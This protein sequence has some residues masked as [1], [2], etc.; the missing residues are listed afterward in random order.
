[1]RRI[2]LVVLVA[3][4]LITAC[5]PSLIP[6]P[7]ATAT[8]I[9]AET[10]TPSFPL[11][12]RIQPT[13]TPDPVA[14]ATARSRQEIAGLANTQGLSNTQVV[15]LWNQKTGLE[16][17]VF[18]YLQS[19]IDKTKAW[20]IPHDQVLAASE[21][22][23]LSLR[24]APAIPGLTR[25]LT[26]DDQGEFVFSYKNAAGD[27]IA[28]LNPLD[29][30]HN[31][32]IVWNWKRALSGAETSLVVQ[33]MFDP[34]HLDL[35]GGYDTPEG[36]TWIVSALS[37][38]APRVLD[39]NLPDFPAIREHY[40]SNDAP[41]PR[42]MFEAL[43]RI[44]T[45]TPS[46]TSTSYGG[47]NGEIKLSRAA[48]FDYP[49]EYNAV[50]TPEEMSLFTFSIAVKEASVIAWAQDH[51]LKSGCSPNDLDNRVE[52]YSTTWLVMVLKSLAPKLSGDKSWISNT[53]IPF[54]QEVL[55]TGR[56]PPCG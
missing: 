36:K 43:S 28:T 38:W 16:S 35:T 14:L 6:T 20:Y 4:I 54:Y 37:K 30:Y 21:Q 24:Q 9:P 52:Y 3:S 45:L 25:T 56:F 29:K 51:D 47:F 33:Q 39:L 10:G 34:E 15:T 17:R 11:A 13:A 1:M 55:Q 44:K 26:V 23:T 5:A 22:E 7:A 32:Q 49:A 48:S 12:E 50:A 40:P 18:S 41:S 46:G 42:I 8:L 53:T 27:E 2:L 31:R 19:T